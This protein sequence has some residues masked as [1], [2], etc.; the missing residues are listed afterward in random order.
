MEDSPEYAGVRPQKKGDCLFHYP[1]QEQKFSVSGTYSPNTKK[2]LLNIPAITIFRE[3]YCFNTQA[4]LDVTK[5][6]KQVNVLPWLS[7][8]GCNVKVCS[9]N[10]IEVELK[11]GLA[12]NIL[13][14]SS[15]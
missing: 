2:A 7:Q 15:R 3:K 9:T 6:T 13:Y 1:T 5:S 14:D 11:E 10:L 8:N 4:M 12:V